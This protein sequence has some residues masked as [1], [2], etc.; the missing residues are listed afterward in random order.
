M[1]GAPRFCSVEVGLQLPALEIPPISRATLSYFAGASGDR[2]PIHLDIDYA[3]SAG[4]PDVF[5]HGMYVMA[6]AGR[7][8]TD[9][10]GPQA[11]RT[12]E[13]RFMA[14]T[15]LF[16]RLYCTARVSAKSANAHG[17]D[18]EIAVEVRNDAGDLKLSARAVVSLSN[19]STGDNP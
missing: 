17:G 3:R 18:V 6:C 8:L 11:L 12:F 9:W 19:D 5:A 15:H 2:N 10:V 16:E 13:A 1:N 4:Q 7:V 14:I